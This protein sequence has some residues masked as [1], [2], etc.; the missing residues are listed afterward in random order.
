MSVRETDVKVLD[1]FV[2]K[3]GKVLRYSPELKAWFI[4]NPDAELPRDTSSGTVTATDGEVGVSLKG[5]PKLS[6]QRDSTR[7]VRS[8][9]AQLIVVETRAGRLPMRYQ[10]M[11]RMN[12]VE[13]LAKRDSHL[14]TYDLV[15]KERS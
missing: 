10:N 13:R 4:L 3:Y 14:V 2:A 15:P 6:W 7:E 5:I 8:F 1:L 11:V 9:L 12:A